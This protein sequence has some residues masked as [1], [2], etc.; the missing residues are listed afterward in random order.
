MSYFSIPRS[1]ITLFSC[2]FMLFAFANGPVL[3][4]T[5]LG[6][7]DLAG[8]SVTPP[9]TVERT[10][11]LG[12]GTVTQLQ[13]SM[14]VQHFVDS[15][16]SETRLTITPPSGAPITISGG[17]MGLPSG[18][19]V[20]ASTN[21]TI[22]FSTPRDASGTW[23][24]G[25]SDSNDDL[26]DPD[27]TINS[28]TLTFQQTNTSQSITAAP[29]TA[30][31]GNSVTFT[32][33]A[34]SA[35]PVSYNLSECTN[36]LAS[37]GS[38][39]L[40]AG[41]CTVTASQAGNATY[42]AA[43]D[44]RFDLTVAPRAVTITADAQSKSYGDTLALD[45]TAFTT[46]AL[47]NGD[48]IDTATFLG[49]TGGPSTADVGTYTDDIKIGSVN[50]SSG[51]DISNYAVTYVAGDL[52]ITPRAITVTAD[53]QSKS[54]GDAL[55]LDNTAF[56][57]PISPNGESI[58][59]VI[60]SSASS[61]DTSGTVDVGTY[62]DEITISG[63][64]GVGGFNPSNYNI[65][66]IS[67]DLTVT[68]RAITVT[69]STQ[70]KEFGETL[71]LD[72]TAFIAPLLPNGEQISQATMTSAN[73]ADSNA[74]VGTYTDD[75][76]ITGIT[77]SNGFSAANYTMSFLA[78]DLVVVDTTAPTVIIGALTATGNGTYTAAI[79]LSEAATDFA[80]EDL[81]LTNAI[82][83]LAGS[84][85]SYIATLTP[86]ADGEIRLS[87]AAD[88]FTDAAGN[89][90]T[91]SIEVTATHDSTGPTVSIGALTAT[92]NGTYTAAIILSEV[93]TDFALED[94]TLTN[95]S[96]T[97]A[98]SGSSYIATLTPSA[99]GE[100]RLSVAAATFTDAAGNNNTAATEV[101]ATYDSTAPTVSIGALTATGNGTYTAAITLSEA[102][103]DFAFEDLTL[104][105]A[106]ATLAGSGSSYIAT[107][108]PSADG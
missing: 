23:K 76:V 4:Q 81:T 51:F 77:G 91:A 26:G 63:A 47:P 86:S 50:G 17:D 3:A 65:S 89:D 8:I 30:T 25:F 66:Y 59:T 31:Y 46:S 10:V 75:I 108:T 99:D 20:L 69:A 79:T 68:P 73:A 78:G 41:S 96:A 15:A 101:T 2:L 106:I 62:I 12:T 105:N 27:Y 83:T 58:D 60:S 38:N 57:A 43:S 11:M 35:L 37:N 61:I 100:I 94:L 56:T 87:V 16:P 44:V 53:T 71:T 85:S 49:S 84:G 74:V 42:S 107:L 24:V 18:G 33:T 14:E 64:S 80:F 98:G 82:A 22:I 88:T 9:A 104:T 67:G 90:N 36:I 39:V 34:S 1:I 7:I 54:Y 40:S 48:S 55:A 28:G 13:V 102:A 103:T 93:A 92:G 97:L 6:S 32:A 95:A 5:N 70:S 45:N 72:D 19:G 52:I 29:V 21:K